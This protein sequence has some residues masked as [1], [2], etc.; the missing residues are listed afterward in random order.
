MSLAPRKYLHVSE[1]LHSG[2]FLDLTNIYS[3]FLI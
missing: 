3:L 1:K 2:I